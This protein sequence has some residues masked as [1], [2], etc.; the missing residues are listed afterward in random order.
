MLLIVAYLYSYQRNVLLIDEPDAHLEILRQKQIYV[1]LRE[2]A[3]ERESQIILATHSE[4]VLEEARDHNLTLLLQGRAD[5]LAAKKDILNTLK[6]YGAEH[7]IRAQQQGYVLYVEGSTDIDILRALAK[8]LNHKAESV[9][10]ERVNAFYVKNTFPMA[11]LNSELERVEGGFDAMPEQHFF[12]LRPMVPNL[13]GLAILD[14]DGH[15]RKGSD[16]GGLQITYWRRYEAENYF[17]T[18]DVLQNYVAEQ[19]QDLTLFDGFRRQTNEVLNGLIQERVFDGSQSDFATW[20]DTNE[21]AKRLLWETRTERLKLSDFAEE[22][23]RHLAQKFGYAMLLRK[24][25][26]HRLVHFVD[27]T[28]IPEEVSEKLDLLQKL[29]EQ[30]NPSEEE[31]EEPE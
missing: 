26:L 3:I 7:Y 12:A 17:I 8:Q 20:R 5:D 11:S 10:D 24:G 29:F 4:V 13:R 22:F 25:E 21:D 18:P 15:E 14:N 6:H 31:S 9:W 19:Y 30:A 16:E 28:T 27:P 23:F 2:I 1:L